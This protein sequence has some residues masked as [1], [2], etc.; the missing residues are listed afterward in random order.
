MTSIDESVVLDADGQYDIAAEAPLSEGEIRLIRARTNGPR[1]TL[2]IEFLARGEDDHLIC[3]ATKS[4]MNIMDSRVFEGY[5]SPLREIELVGGWDRIAV[6]RDGG[7]TEI[8]TE[9]GTF[10]APSPLRSHRNAHGGVTFGGLP[11]TLMDVGLTTAK[12]TDNGLVLH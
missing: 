1:N 6:W 3:V 5:G 11:Y 8:K 12:L 9:L 10:F 2:S 7:T 4:D